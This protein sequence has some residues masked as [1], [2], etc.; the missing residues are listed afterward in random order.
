MISIADIGF[1]LTEKGLEAALE[2]LLGIE[3]E[4]LVRLKRIEGKL[5]ILQTGPYKSGMHHL[6]SALQLDVDQAS[7]R[8]E[9]DKARDAFIEA[10]DQLGDDPITQSFTAV[11][12]AGTATV[13]G[14]P[15]AET[16]RWLQRAYDEAARG[17]STRCE[18]LTKQVSRRELPLAWAHGDKALYRLNIRPS[19]L[20]SGVRREGRAEVEQLDGYVRWIGEMRR[21]LGVPDSEI[22][23]YRIFEGST[24]VAAYRILERSKDSLT[25]QL[26]SGWR[27]RDP[28]PSSVANDYWAISYDVPFEPG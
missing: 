17:T 14:F 28:S 10:H 5:S 23:P 16:Q 26:R 24:E 20:S 9:V 27:Q 6:E 7:A 2:K 15:S 12:A 11:L 25:R 8:R 4:Q 13:L 18:E 1:G 22:A 3:N 19:I 21:Q